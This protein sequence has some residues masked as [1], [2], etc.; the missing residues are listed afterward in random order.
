MD[1]DDGGRPR[2]R[3][4]GL[5]RGRRRGP[6]RPRRCASLL[7]D[8]A[9]GDALKGL[10]RHAR[11]FPSWSSTTRLATRTT[12]VLCVTSRTPC[13]CPARS[14]RSSSSRDSVS[15]SSSPVGSSAS[16]TAGSLASAT[17]SPARAAS[18]PESWRGYARRRV[19]GRPR[20]PAAPD[21]CASHDRPATGRD[22][23]SP[24]RS[25]GR[26]GC[27]TGRGLRCRSLGY[28]PAQP[29]SGG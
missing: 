16:R 4:F 26:P 17:A 22:G 18:P 20:R 13:P 28:V 27:R 7:E 8:L 29:R 3:R 6:S 24:G 12:S 15:P 25:D 11:T 14:V 23:R 1:R 5:P 10:S 2:S 19:P 21:R 9:E